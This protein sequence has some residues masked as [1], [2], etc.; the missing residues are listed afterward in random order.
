MKIIIEDQDYEL[1]FETAVAYGVLKRI[2]KKIED[3]KVGDVFECP[4]SKIVI[5]EYSFV[6]GVVVTEQLYDIHSINFGCKKHSNFLD[7]A[8][9][10]DML[11]HLNRNEYKFV[12]NIQQEFKELIKNA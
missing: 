3:F 1:N 2:H 11:K 4:N 8:T 5:F 12:G 10:E 9:K 7:G 6:D